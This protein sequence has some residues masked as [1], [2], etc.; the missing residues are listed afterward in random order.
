ML[1]ERN[2]FVS[3]IKPLEEFMWQLN[4]EC[5]RQ[6]LQLQ[7]SEEMKR[8][9]KEVNAVLNKNVFELNYQLIEDLCPKKEI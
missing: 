7:L 5:V 8:K 4:E 9:M 2:S 3:K 1:S 6:S